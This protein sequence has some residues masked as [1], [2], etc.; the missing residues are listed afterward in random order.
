[1][2]ENFPYNY[3]KCWDKFAGIPCL[4]CNPERDI[5]YVDGIWGPMLIRAGTW[6][7][8][9]YSGFWIPIGDAAAVSERF[10]E[11]STEEW[12]TLHTAYAKQ[13]YRCT[14]EDNG[15]YLQT[16]REAIAKHG[17]SD[18]DPPNWIRELISGEKSQGQNPRSQ[19]S[20]ETVGAR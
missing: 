8:G 3:A 14:D 5:R 15:P 18:P 6:S 1:M 4:V 10:V 9:D 11:L 17:M 20:R 19:E 2:V 16:I 12:E 13:V 7:A